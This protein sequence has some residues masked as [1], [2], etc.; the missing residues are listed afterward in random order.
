LAIS[1]SR[2][3]RSEHSSATA[4]RRRA[5]AASAVVLLAVTGVALADDPVPI[6]ITAEATVT[7]NK[8]GT[9]RHPQGVKIDV[10]A[11]ID[12]PS[13]YDPPLVR[14][15]DVWFPKGGLYN[16]AKFPTCSKQTMDRRG[17]SA[18]PKGSIMGHGR[19]KAAAD[20]VFTYPTITVVNGGAHT[21]YFYTVLTN[22]ARVAEPVVAT[23]T[24][25]SGGPWSY[26]LHASIPRDLQIVAGIPLRLEQLHITAGRGDWVA[27][28][29]CPADHRW[30]YHVESN[31]DTGQ[32]ITYDGSVA[33]RS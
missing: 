5:F 18:C 20:T 10:T 6:K 21:V 26:K 15:V 33:C 27:T 16:G 14:T 2:F 11:H 4:P 13:D 8:A 23:I 25:L 28:T 30:K 24:R 1:R 31:F 19:G 32:T 7:P 29:S 22:P 12:I 9:P 3:W 17:V